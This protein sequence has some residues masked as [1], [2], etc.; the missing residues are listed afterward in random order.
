MRLGAATDIEPGHE[1]EDRSTPADLDADDRRRIED[2]A[3]GA[4][5][6]IDLGG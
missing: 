6:A 2:T 4:G 5:H 3:A 1:A